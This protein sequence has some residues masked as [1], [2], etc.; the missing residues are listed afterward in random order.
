MKRP[1][2]LCGALALLAV[3]APLTASAQERGRTDGPEESEY[4]TG[5]YYGDSRRGV[6]LQLD[7]GAAINSQ[8]NPRGAPEG[9]PLFVGATVSLWG[10]DWYRLD[11]SGAYVFDGGR[12]IG[13]V[14]PTF[15]SWGWPVAFTLG[16]KAGAMVIPEGEGLRFALSPQVGAELYLDR[17]DHVLMGLHYSPD[18]PIGGGGVTNRLFMNVGYRF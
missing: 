14:G 4:G 16:L 5:G 17:R 15:R 1:V 8:E 3:A 11:V 7:W 10:D 18:I 6:S 2:T 9:P 12:F 13:N